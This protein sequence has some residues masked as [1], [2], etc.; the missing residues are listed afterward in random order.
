MADC[1]KVAADFVSLQS[2]ERCSRLTAEFR[3][4]NMEEA[5]KEDVL[6]LKNLLW[7]AWAALQRRSVLHRPPDRT[8]PTVPNLNPGES[9]KRAASTAE[10]VNKSRKALRLERPYSCP[11]CTKKKFYAHGLIA[12]L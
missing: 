1:I 10:P 3:A 11:R 5:W 6:E 2:L 4:Q 8:Q 12:H 9:R 7:H